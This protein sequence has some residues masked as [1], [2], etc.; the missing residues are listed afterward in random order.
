MSTLDRELVDW[1]AAIALIG[2][3]STMIAAMRAKLRRNKEILRYL[4]GREHKCPLFGTCPICG[5]QYI[6]TVV[7]TQT[8]QRKS[9]SEDQ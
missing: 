9:G 4:Q 2:I 1:A 6:F 8:P 3:I 7:S 5:H